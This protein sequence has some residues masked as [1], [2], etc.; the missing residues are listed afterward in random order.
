VSRL[1][2]GTLTEDLAG[3]LIGV[4]VTVTF[5]TAGELFRAPP[6]LAGGDG[7]SER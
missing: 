2:R 7:G 1:L 3:R 4:T 5:V 6:T